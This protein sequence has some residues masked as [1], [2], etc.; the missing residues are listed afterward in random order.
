M[1][2]RAV[3]AAAALVVLAV[4]VIAGRLAW[5]RA[6][7]H[8]YEGQLPEQIHIGGMVHSGVMQALIDGCGAV[9]FTMGDD[10][11]QA[12]RRDG[13]RALQGAGQARAHKAPRDAYGPW[14]ATPHRP[15]GDGMT[16]A[17]RWLLGLNC[18]DLPAD[19]GDTIEQA[20]AGEGAFYATRPESGLILIPTRRL[21]VF[22]FDG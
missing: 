6:Q 14:Q 8:W 7:A 2:R 15:T 16:T 22:S 4:V 11:V 3:K 19:L 10:T 12:L 13:L 20:L 1:A 18:A 9:V 17:D 5:S 21:V